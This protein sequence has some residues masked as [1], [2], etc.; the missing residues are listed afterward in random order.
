[1]QNI[2][3]NT[4]WKKVF[5]LD[6]FFISQLYSNRKKIYKIFKNNIEVDTN[7]KILDVGT[8]PTLDYY[9][10]FFIH[11]Y[12]WKN[13][14]T[15]LSDQD[16]SIL[17]SRYDEL[18]ML[19]GDGRKVDLPNASFDIVYS[20]AVIEHVGDAVN[21][22]NFIKECVRLTKKK[23]FITTPNRYFPLDFHTKLPL[24]HMLP[25]K[26]FRKILYLLGD[27]F[28]RFEKNLN[29]LSKNDLIKF[30]E[31]LKI[32]K[33]KILSHRFLYLVSNLIL[34]IEK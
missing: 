33:Y 20:S 18:N 13:N 19:L 14:I 7:T 15:C 3:K 16:C 32:K 8:T 29:L 10:N 6:N 30:C 5:L 12:P 1:M 31:E 23:V 21:Q 26:F 2:K 9:E 27:N 34:V 4:Y 24:I 11:A 25:K 17:K 22:K 28:F